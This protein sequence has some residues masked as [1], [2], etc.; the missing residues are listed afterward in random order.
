MIKRRAAEAGHV[1]LAYLEV[2]SVSAFG[3][4]ALTVPVS[5]AQLT[6]CSNKEKGGWR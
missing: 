6:G 4:T 3:V 1:F 5:I 2:I